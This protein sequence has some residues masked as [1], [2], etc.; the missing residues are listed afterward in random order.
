MSA[1]AT[2]APLHPYPSS[3]AQSKLSA[4]QFASLNQKISL[5]IQKTLDL[6]V[7]TMNSAAAIAFI[8]SYARDVA[9]NI[10]VDR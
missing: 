4:S 1:V 5:I 2:L 6:P 8:S 10:I 9:Q 3:Y 7:Q